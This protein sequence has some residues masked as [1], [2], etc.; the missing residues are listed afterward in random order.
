[1]TPEKEPGKVI[2]IR[3]K[4]EST[5]DWRDR[6]VYDDRGRIRANAAN[7]TTILRSD[8]NWDGVLAWDEFRFAPVF[9]REPPWT[10]D[11]RPAKCEAGELTDQDATRFSSW[12]VRRYS[13]QVGS[14]VALDGAII[15]CQTNPFHPVREWL[16]SLTWDG[17]RRVPTWLASYLGA[18]E[19][20]APYLEMVGKSILVSAVARVY[21][22][23]CKVDTMGV[24]EG[25]QGALKSSAISALVGNEWFSD[26]PVDFASKD[27]FVALRGRWVHEFAELE[28]FGRA[29][30]ASL[31]AYLSSPVDDYR[32]PY[33]RSQLR[34]PRQCIFVGT[35]NPDTYL[36]DDTGNRRYLPVR[37]GTINL[38]AIHRDREQL[39]A[40]AREMFRGGAQWWP[41]RETSTLCREQQTERMVGDEWQSLVEPF[42]VTH[43]A[44]Y[45]YVAVTEVLGDALGIEKGKWDQI[46]QTRAARCLRAI[47]RDGK[48]WLKRCRRR[49]GGS[50]SQAWVYAPETSETST[51]ETVV[52]E[53]S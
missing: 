43:V 36:R 18:T 22:P 53:N 26:T 11:D 28:G 32:P 33:G 9:L 39:W 19:Q 17:A 37:C 21:R 1:V 8:E 35:V 31:K 15:A 45:G 6:L 4:R 20:P 16:D 41:D 49:I 2:P 27:R 47:E 46:T 14:S 29:E 30:V 44:R 50:G 40:E 10:E 13:F 42:A 38:D 48:Q 3:R 25:H 23:G 34:V 51:N 12:L 24:L 5:G 52:S 7:V